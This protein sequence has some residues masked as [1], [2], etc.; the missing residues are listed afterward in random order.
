MKPI[1][2]VRARQ[3]AR[4]KKAQAEAILDMQLESI[5]SRQ[6]QQQ[7]AAQQS[8]GWGDSYSHLM[9]LQ[10]QNVGM[11][12]QAGIANGGA[13]TAPAL[14]QEEEAQIE[15]DAERARRP[16]WRLW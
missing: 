3:S 13:Y 9:A 16:W 15:R 2:R 7:M 10:A 4:I 11:A 14:T 12:L 5:R 8:A 6:R 1:E